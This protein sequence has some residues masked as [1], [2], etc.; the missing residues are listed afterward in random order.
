VAASKRMFCR[1]STGMLKRD[2]VPSPALFPVVAGSTECRLTPGRAGS[3]ESRFLGR[4]D[5]SAT[6]DPESLF[7]AARLRVRPGNCASASTADVEWSPSALECCSIEGTVGAGREDDEI[8]GEVMSPI[9]AHRLA[10]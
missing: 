1:S 8:R 6:S 4:D 3:T 10:Y 5:A 7:F 2:G 9:A